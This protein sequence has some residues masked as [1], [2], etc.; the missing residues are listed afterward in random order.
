MTSV[1]HRSVCSSDHS[2]LCP[3]VSD[4]G[5]NADENFRVVV[6]ELQ[7]KFTT[8]GTGFSDLHKAFLLSDVIKNLSDQSLLLLG[9]PNVER[10]RGKQAPQLD[11]FYSNLKK[12]LYTAFN[13]IADRDTNGNVYG[14]KPDPKDPSK[15]VPN[16]PTGWFVKNFRLKDESDENA[17]NL[18]GWAAAEEEVSPRNIRIN[19]HSLSLIAVLHYT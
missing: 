9:A 14:V 2:G 13:V 16:R 1:V 6:T 15:T 17:E 5:G 19:R 18:L 3:Q 8:A 11:P 4:Q 12:C 10:A 7:S